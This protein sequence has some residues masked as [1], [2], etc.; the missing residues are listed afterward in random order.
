MGRRFGGVIGLVVVASLAWVA[1]APA[2]TDGHEDGEGH[3]NVGALLVDLPS[4][5]TVP[6]CSGSVLSPTEFLT[7]GHCTDFLDGQGLRPNQVS[8]SFQS[9][10]RLQD[11][12][13]VAPASRIQSTGWV[14]HPL[15]RAHLAK[16]YDDVGV[17][18]LAAPASRRAPVQL[19]TAG[20]LDDQAA[21]GGLRGHVFE[22]VGYGVNAVDRSVLS[23]RANVV[24]FGKRYVSTSPFMALTPYFLKL[25]GNS[26]ATGMG[27]ACFGDSGGPAFWTPGSPLEVAVTTAG[28]PTCGALSERQRLDTRSVLGFLAA[29]RG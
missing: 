16:D 25:L 9:D 27:G 28:D 14:T 7:A 11:D 10:L 23:P 24:W 22:T 29:F 26:N 15:F 3:P 13:T 4:V 8:V 1:P 20:Y 2:I 18:H 19:P 5:G 17:V 6:L 21:A 12:G